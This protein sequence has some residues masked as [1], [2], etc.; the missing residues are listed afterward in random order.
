MLLAVHLL[1]LQSQCAAEA[2]ICLRHNVTR[3]ADA[4]CLCLCVILQQDDNFDTDKTRGFIGN[5]VTG[6]LPGNAALGNS[7]CWLDFPPANTIV[8]AIPA[9]CLLL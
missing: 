9:D 2:T 7:C 1:L 5:A 3:R 8:I 4:A 6:V